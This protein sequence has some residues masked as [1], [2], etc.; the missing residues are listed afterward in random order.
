MSIKDILNVTGYS[1]CGPN[2]CKYD[3]PCWAEAW[4]STKMSSIM[5]IVPG[6]SWELHKIPIGLAQPES[7]KSEDCASAVMEVCARVG[8]T[9][10]DILGSVNDTASA[11]KKTG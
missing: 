3:H 11:E 5:F 2:Q 10:A 9:A 7:H 4:S 6:D 8:V 1:I